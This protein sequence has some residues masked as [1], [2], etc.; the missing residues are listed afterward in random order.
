MELTGLTNQIDLA[1]IPDLVGSAANMI[2]FAYNPAD[3]KV[4]R[5][6]ASQLIGTGDGNLIARHNATPGT[7]TNVSA[8]AGKAVNAVF[9]GGYGCGKIVAVAPSGNEVQWDSVSCDLTVATNQ[10]WV[11]GEELMIFYTN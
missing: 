8:L 10:D 11:D 1:Q 4:Y 7:V 6:S 5:I 2:W 9:R 3:K